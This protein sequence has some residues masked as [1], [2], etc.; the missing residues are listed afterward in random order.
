MRGSPAHSREEE[1]LLNSEYNLEE[2]HHL[3]ALNLEM[4]TT[5]SN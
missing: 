4:P 3:A 1:K 2:P 5:R